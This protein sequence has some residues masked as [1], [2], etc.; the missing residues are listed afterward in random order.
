MAGK[1]VSQIKK[2]A[3]S[4]GRR[5]VR[6]AFFINNKGLAMTNTKGAGVSVFKEQN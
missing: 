4:Q 1:S 2:A 5:Q 3:E 6:Q